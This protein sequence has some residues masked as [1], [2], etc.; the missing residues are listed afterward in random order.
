[1]RTFAAGVLLALSGAALAAP[2]RLAP[3]SAAPPRLAIPDPPPEL[4]AAADAGA[5]QSLVCRAVAGMERRM[6]CLRAEMRED[7]SAIWHMSYWLDGRR[8]AAWIERPRAGNEAP[9]FTLELA[10]LD[11]TGAP[12]LVVAVNGSVHVLGQN[13]QHLGP[14]PAPS[15]GRDS[16]AIR[17]GDERR[18]VL[19]LSNGSDA[20][21]YRLNGGRLVS[22]QP[23]R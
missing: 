20:R 22:V 4:R 8:R 7:G 15:W 19:R 12:E 11:G 3:C 21:W 17:I 16:Q 5:N 6:V 9:A 10:Q 1:M 13:G 2:P 14:L 23:P 18:C